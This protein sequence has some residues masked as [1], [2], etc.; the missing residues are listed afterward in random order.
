MCAHATVPICCWLVLGVCVASILTEG[1]L[2]PALLVGLA[3]LA[4]TTLGVIDRHRETHLLPTGT[5]TP[6][7]VIGLLFAAVLRSSTSPSSAIS[8]CRCS[9]SS[10]T[11]IAARRRLHAGPR[12]CRLWEQRFDAHLEELDRRVLRLLLLAGPLL[13]LAANLGLAASVGVDNTT[14]VSRCCPSGSASSP[15]APAS[16]SPGRRFPP[17]IARRTSGR[18]RP[19]LGF[20]VDGA[21]LRLGPRCRPC[22]RHR[23]RRR[24]CRQSRPRDHHRRS[25]LALRPLRHRA[26]ARPARRLD[27]GHREHATA[28]TQP[29]E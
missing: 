14:I 4:I 13:Q 16:A 2:L 23:Q 12:R 22:R 10:C 26:V 9:S 21:A 25:P 15:S 29:A 24:P 17:F 7:S 27:L 18:R 6:G 20:P 1:A 8:S 28:L 3:V 19:D 11:L 5:F